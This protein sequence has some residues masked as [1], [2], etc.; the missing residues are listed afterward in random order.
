MLKRLLALAAMLPAMALADSKVSEL[1]AV[2]SVLGPEL[3]YCVQGS[4]DRKC[5]VDQF[6]T[7][8]LAGV[9]QQASALLGTT[10]ASNVVNSSLLTA[11]GGAFGTAA[12]TAA[13]AYEVAGAAA[14]A[15]AASQPLDSDL[16]AIAALAT[17]TFG[18]SLLTAADAA[19]GRTSFGLGAL[20]TVTP[21]TGVA[22]AAANA[23]NATGGVVTYGG[24]GGALGVLSLTAT[25]SVTGNPA[26][27]V[28][29]GGTLTFTHPSSVGSLV[30]EQQA[31]SSQPEATGGTISGHDGLLKIMR[32]ARYDP[33]TSKWYRGPGTTWAHVDEWGQGS[34]GW[35]VAPTGTANAE[36][37]STL[38]QVMNLSWQ[39]GSDPRL[40]WYA[41]M[42]LEF[43]N[44]YNAAGI[45]YWSAQGGSPNY[46]YIGKLGDFVLTPAAN[47]APISISGYSLTSTNAQPGISLTG[48][49]STSGTPTAVKVAII[50][51]ASNANSLLLD[52]KA[53]ASATTPVL[54]AMATGNVGIG[55][56]TPGTP[57]EINV[58][59]NAI[60]QAAIL[61]A[62]AGSSAGA[63]FYVGSVLS[64]GHYGSFQYVGAG[65]S[66][67]SIQTI[68]KSTLI[69]GQD[70]GGIIIGSSVGPVKFFSGGTTLDYEVLRLDTSG[71]NAIFG[72]GDGTAT[73]TSTTIRAP[74]SAGT[75]IAGANLT[76][77]S[78]NGRG[79]ATPSL[80]TLSTPVATT[81][82]SGAQTMTAT[83]T[84]GN[85]Q[86]KIGSNVIN[87]AG[88]G[89]RYLC[90]DTGGVVSSS[91]SACSGT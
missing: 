2:T 50:N 81:S 19:A 58:N 76:V 89:T 61:N 12:F 72:S 64:G 44:A 71:N 33:A 57:L 51:T 74:S 10:L 68:L 84:L 53:G 29:N 70:V 11:A 69:Q 49:W 82:G 35:Y 79:N 34:R 40:K 56:V 47:V 8:I 75:N 87:P 77:T 22:T 39:G 54:A 73:L 24:N 48:T 6:K 67:G 27:A 5:T 36:I 23:T 16:T 65:A 86:F 9:S 42:E 41:P 45:L 62:N 31:D 85:G 17:T 37:T 4:A 90:I 32:N 43:D 52:L 21:G 55:T 18:R 20:A 25:P 15:Q 28:T 80:L 13:S 66:S 59:Q 91:A 83:L 3:V 38:R 46:G 30:I 26:I 78:G 60:T 7:Y 14:A 1:T 63:A 88:S